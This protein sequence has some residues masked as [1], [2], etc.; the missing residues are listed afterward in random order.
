MHDTEAYGLR[1]ECAG[2]VLAHSGGSGPCAALIELAVESDVFLC[3]AD[4]DRHREGEQVH[5]TPK[6]AGRA[7]P[8]P[9]W[10]PPGSSDAAAAQRRL[11][12]PEALTKQHR[13]LTFNAS[14]FVRHI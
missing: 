5:L 6:D 3:E 9:S 4:I 11:P 13:P 2:R 12:L 7:R 8:P 10:A 1:A 14:Y